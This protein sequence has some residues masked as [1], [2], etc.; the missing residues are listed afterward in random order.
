[1]KTFT[2]D[3]NLSCWVQG[4]EVE[5]DSYEEALEILNSMSADEIVDEGYVKRKDI[6]DIDY[7]VE[8]DEEDEEEFEDDED[9]LDFDDN[10]ELADG[11]KYDENVGHIVYPNDDDDDEE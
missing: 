8:D 1:M 11:G 5:A 4:I 7:D 10:Y 3:I 9:D 2:F 6:S